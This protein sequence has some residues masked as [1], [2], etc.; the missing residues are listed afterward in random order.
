MHTLIFTCLGLLALAIICWQ[1]WRER[2][3]EK[4]RIPRTGRR[5]WYA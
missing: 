3:T 2:V 1:A 4:Q 5:R